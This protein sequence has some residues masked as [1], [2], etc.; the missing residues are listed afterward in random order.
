M[1]THLIVL[2]E[3]KKNEDGW[4]IASKNNLDEWHLHNFSLELAEKFASGIFRA[5]KIVRIPNILFPARY[6]IQYKKI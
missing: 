4:K 5:S 1:E 6:I 3:D 2:L